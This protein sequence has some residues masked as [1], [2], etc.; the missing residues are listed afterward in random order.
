MSAKPNN[1][2]EP[3]VAPFVQISIFAPKTNQSEVYGLKAEGI[4]LQTNSPSVWSCPDIQGLPYPD[5]NNS[6]WIIG[7]QYFGGFTSWTPP[8]GTIAG[9]HSPVK[10][11]ESMPYWC[12]AADLIMKFN[13]VWG[14][15]DTDLP[16]AAQS[17]C[18][19]I[20][21]HREGSARYPEGGDEVFVDCSA[22]FCPVSTMCQFT[23]W[24]PST[25]K[26]WFYQSVADIT[27]PTTLET[28]NSLKWQS[29]DE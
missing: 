5:T 20:P 12:L 2:A 16:A 23:T 9:T 24:T 28:I 15:V 7:Y 3:T 10:L 29:S 1:L 14:S 17:A 8:T 13:G 21:Q 22:R 6:Q 27:D 18:K 4:P 19:Y 26:L 11:T 25:R